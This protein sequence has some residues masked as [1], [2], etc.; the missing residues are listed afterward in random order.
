MRLRIP[1]RRSLILLSLMIFTGC[2]SAVGQTTRGLDWEIAVISSPQNLSR[3]DRYKEISRQLAQG[4]GLTDEQAKALA[5]EGKAIAHLDGGLHSTEVAG[6]QH[7]I[8]LA[9]NLVSA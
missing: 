7:S 5:R 6:A 8:Q 4:R 2:G 3:L 1:S 9:Y